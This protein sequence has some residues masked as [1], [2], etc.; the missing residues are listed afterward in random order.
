MYWI[1]I[2]LLDSTSN[3]QHLKP[4]LL[5]I[6]PPTP[7]VTNRGG[8]CINKIRKCDRQRSFFRCCVFNSHN[9]SIEKMSTLDVSSVSALE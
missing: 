3:N 7:H 4:C 5:S 2:Y 9:H 6:L 1:L 8:T